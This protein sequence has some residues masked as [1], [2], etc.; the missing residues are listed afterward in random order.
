MIRTPLE[1]CHISS[2]WWCSILT[3]NGIIPE[4]EIQLCVVIWVKRWHIR[5][6]RVS[7]SWHHSSHLQWRVG[8]VCHMKLHHV[9]RLEC[10]LYF[11]QTEYRWMVNR[12][13]LH[14]RERNLISLELQCIN[15]K[16]DTKVWLPYCVTLMPFLWNML[17]HVYTDGSSVFDTRPPEGLVGKWSHYLN[18][19]RTR[20]RKEGGIVRDSGK[21]ERKEERKGM[22]NDDTKEKI[23]CQCQPTFSNSFSLFF[24]KKVHCTNHM[25]LTLR[26]PVRH[27]ER[28]NY[29]YTPSRQFGMSLSCKDIIQEPGNAHELRGSGRTYINSRLGGKFLKHCVRNK[30]KS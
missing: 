15:V 18:A 4:T 28:S 17:L 1:G 26:T 29:W 22:R 30:K 13:A 8:S 14:T 21:K 23:S 10:R 5:Q 11:K 3:A 12:R 24:V 9:G 16:G 7:C 27:E 2:A 19:T 25:Q 20:L 6:S